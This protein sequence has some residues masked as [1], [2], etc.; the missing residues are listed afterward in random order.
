MNLQGSYDL[1]RIKAA[2]AKD[3]ARIA[4]RRTAGAAWASEHHI[5]L[6]PG[7]E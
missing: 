5:L 6:T 2:I 7:I 4:P 3:V 1:R